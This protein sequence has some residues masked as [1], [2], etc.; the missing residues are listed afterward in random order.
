MVGLDHDTNNYK[1]FLPHLV[2]YSCRLPSL[3]LHGQLQ[4]WTSVPPL[5]V[6]C[7]TWLMQ[8]VSRKR[9]ANCNLSMALAN[10]SHYMVESCI[11]AV[12]SSLGDIPTKNQWSPPQLSQVILSIRTTVMLSTFS[13]SMKTKW[14]N[15]ITWLQQK[16]KRCF[17]HLLW[18]TKTWMQYKASMDNVH[19][20]TSN[21]VQ[22]RWQQWRIHH[23]WRLK[24]DKPK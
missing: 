1:Q 9:S 3:P 2:P 12:L 19:S 24:L 14:Q 13:F 22:S 16:G 23:L 5:T 6:N 11:V 15:K 20:L 21:P 18:Q 7:V 17:V 4:W 8:N 10:I